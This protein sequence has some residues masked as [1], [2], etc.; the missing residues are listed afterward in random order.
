MANKTNLNKTANE[1]PLVEIPE[2]NE[3]ENKKNLKQI[4]EGNVAKK[5][6][7]NAKPSSESA[8][9]PE[10]KFA[11]TF[12]PSK[13]GFANSYLVASYGKDKRMAQMSRIIPSSV[14][15]KI[16]ASIAS[17]GHGPRE[18][19]SPEEI[20]ASL[21]T[22]GVDSLEK[23][24]AAM[25]DLERIASE[26]NSKECKDEK[27]EDEKESPAK[28][29][30]KEASLK[31]QAGQSAPLMAFNESEA[32]TPEKK[33]RG[34]E[35]LAAHK[36]EPGHPVETPSGAST[37]AKKY[38]ANAFPGKPQA[39]G[40]PLVSRKEAGINSGLYKV[41]IDALRKD[42]DANREATE[43]ALARAAA[44]EQEVAKLKEEK[45]LDDVSETIENLL[46][47]MES[48]KLIGKEAFKTL[49]PILKKLDEK[50]LSVLSE[51]VQHL[52]AKSEDKGA[53]PKSLDDM[54]MDKDLGKGMDKG[55]GPKPPMLGGP[56][57]PAMPLPG[58]K[59]SFVPHLN[60][61]EVGKDDND[62]NKIW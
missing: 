6:I 4:M 34:A 53:M 27:K 22:Q 2:I 57:M 38:W 39:G 42:A 52:T 33:A 59:A 32:N 17:T 20:I 41:R 31:V 54:G 56:K 29:V 21:S 60:V 16:I 55:M 26:E 47:D 12:V 37:S 1:K 7:D 13:D 62:L 45:A 28:D 25:Q 10:L 44:A 3:M 50:G 35:P 19:V 36:D 46:E 49:M 23:F 30:K 18:V 9:A 40:E 15:N 43:K 8:N 48:K 61:A 51:V 24:V 5:E 58:K 11:M 14:Q